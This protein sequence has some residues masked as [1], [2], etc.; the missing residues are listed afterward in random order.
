MPKNKKQIKPIA[1][2]VSEA[3]ETPLRR[4]NEKN[5]W[6]AGAPPWE[7]YA[8]ETSDFA[9][10]LAGLAE[11][12]GGPGSTEILVGS[13]EDVA[14]GKVKLT[15][16]RL[17]G[18][19]PLSERD[20]LL[21]LRRDGKD[22]PLREDAFALGSEEGGRVVFSSDAFYYILLTD[23]MKYRAMQNSYKF[24]REDPLYK[25][26]VTSLVN[27]IIGRGL[28]FKA[29]DENP[30]VQDYIQK[31]WQINKMPGKDAEM[32][33]RYLLTG[34]I[35]ARLYPQGKNGVAAQFPALRLIP[36][37]RLAEVLKDPED[38]EEI[39]GF[40]IWRAAGPYRPQVQEDTVPPEEVLFWKNS[41]PEED[42][43]EPPLLAAMRPCK[44]YQDWI[45]NRVMLNRFRTSIVLFKK[46][47]TGTPGKVSGVSSADPA[48]TNHTG[49]L[50]KVE[51]RLPK[52][53]TVITHNDKI[54]YDWKS[55]QLDAS[56]AANDGRLIMLYVACAAQVPEFLLGDASNANMASTFVA[57]NPF[58]RQIEAHQTY[59]SGFFGEMFRRVIEHGIATGALP[60]TSTE[61]TLTESGAIMKPVRRV[62]HK[63]GL[64]REATVD[65]DGN[66]QSQRT[67]PTRTDIV[68][69]WPEL[70]HKNQFEDAQTRQIDQAM[71]LAS[72]ETLRGKAGYDHEVEKKRL[73][74]E[75]DAELDAYDAARQ[76]ELDQA[77]DEGGDGDPQTSGKGVPDGKGKA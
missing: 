29:L 16:Q 58:I 42:R 75:G 30:A 73:E 9:A 35:C 28:K 15:H 21:S 71:G 39:I 37:W 47:I 2:P 51:K 74:D 6:L 54:E 23:D 65:A 3:A 36:F 19:V 25:G 55:P 31:F 59:F 57:E 64:L 24:F 72:K 27:F 8:A 34:E 11:E 45:Q 61:T 7:S 17:P 60:A 77:D 76:A 44:W 66:Q 68:I 10:G 49:A 50:G 52:S 13:I 32:I 1:P 70:L 12:Q 38:A 5:M 69:D 43:G 18:D 62:L 40:K 53:G 26:L 63:L 22:A 48:A 4:V 46:I 20:G 33:K 56:D 67:I 14:G 41:T